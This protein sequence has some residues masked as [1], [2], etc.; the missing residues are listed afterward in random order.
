MLRRTSST[1]SCQR[2]KATDAS[3]QRD[4]LWSRYR[5]RGFSE[6]PEITD[7]TDSRRAHQDEIGD[8]FGQQRT[9]DIGRHIIR[10][11]RQNL[12]DNVVRRIR[13]AAFVTDTVLNN[14]P[15]MCAHPHTVG[16]MRLRWQ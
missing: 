5:S 4:S 3:F 7:L 6:K 8:E 1:A 12:S 10:E 15:V 13:E 2:G 11:L 9:R 16:E 14:G